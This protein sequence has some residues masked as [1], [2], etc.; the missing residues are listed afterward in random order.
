MSDLLPSNRLL[1]S[2][3]ACI[4]IC[5][6]LVSRRA[7]KAPTTFAECFQLLKEQGVILEPLCNKLKQMTRFH[8]LI[9]HGYWKVD[10]TEVYRILQNSLGDFD[11][12]IQ[13][14]EDLILKGSK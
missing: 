6:H 5:D 4:G 1:L 3:E 14:V 10:D 9:V 12:Y 13:S 8:N 11:A 2:I 7:R